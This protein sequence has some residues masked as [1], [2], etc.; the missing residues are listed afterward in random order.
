MYFARPVTNAR[1]ST[2]GREVPMRPFAAIGDAPQRLDPAQADN[3]GGCEKP[4]PE[5][6]YKGLTTGEDLCVAPVAR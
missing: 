5:Q 3:N 1:P 2:L 6:D 4:L